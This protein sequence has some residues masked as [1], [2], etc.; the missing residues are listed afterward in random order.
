[1]NNGDKNM[2]V[3]E[4]KVDE[5]A[6]GQR[7]DLFLV[8]GQNDIS[9]TLVR[10]RINEGGVVLNGKLE[11][12]PNYKVKIDDDI[13]FT[14]QI[15][16][17]SN[18]DLKPEN[19]PI[20]IIYEDDDLVVVDKPSGMVIHPATG[21]SSGTLMNAILYHF[22]EISKIGNS[23]R[24]GLIHRID[25][26]TSGLVMIG[27]SNKGLW[28]YSKLFAEREVNKTYIAILAG[29]IATRIPK[30]GLIV[31]NYLGR[32]P[33]NRKK[34][35]VVEP[36]K[37]RNAETKIKLLKVIK[38]GTKY[39]SVVT[40]SPKTGRTHQIRVHLS[41]LGY[42]ILGDVIYG[43][44]NRYKRLML[45]AWKIKVKLLNDKIITFEAPLPNSFLDFISNET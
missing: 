7:L 1:M 19:L 45:H 24:S 20:D 25:K 3:K 11:Y 22:K 10:Q 44:H 9:R 42:P 14:Y 35:S 36:G 28:Y 43:K 5:Q 41:S 8:T 13:C 38:D 17:P 37:G 23:I 27:K 26:D 34:Y 29:N 30:E 33:G 31:R 6:S 18:N 16:I 12:R 21:N 40:A 32:N 2:I 15:N 39:Y 4:L